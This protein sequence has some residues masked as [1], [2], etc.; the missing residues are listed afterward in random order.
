M[1]NAMDLIFTPFIVILIA[2]AIA[3]FILGPLVHGF[4]H[5]AVMAIE[6]FRPARRN[7]RSVDRVYL[8]HRGDD[9]DASY[10]HYD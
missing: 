2:I 4:E 1:P 7:W 5:Y 3:L 8:S 9:R 10:V 6:Q